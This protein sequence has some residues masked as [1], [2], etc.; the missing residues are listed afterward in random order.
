MSGRRTILRIAWTFLAIVLA[1]PVIGGEAPREYQLKAAFIYNFV[2]FVDWPASAFPSAQSPVVLATVG[3]DPFQGALDQAAA[4][5]SAG[6]RPLLVKHFAQAADVNR[7]QLL[8]IAAGQEDQLAAARTRLG[9]AP[10]LT[11]GESEEFIRAGGMIRFYQEDNRLR[12]EINPSAAHKA[13]L[14]ISSR[15]LKLAKIRG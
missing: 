4:G 3:A 14:R 11:V 10:V 13:G 12:F 1:T 9:D 6:R 15:L 2:Q 8:F 7:C 5:K